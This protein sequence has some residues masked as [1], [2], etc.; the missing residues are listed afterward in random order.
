[1]RQKDLLYIPLI[2]GD[3]NHQRAAEILLET[4]SFSQNLSTPSLLHSLQLSC[5]C[6]SEMTLTVLNKVVVNDMI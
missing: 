4:W 3:L 6:N 5:V 2:I 1:M